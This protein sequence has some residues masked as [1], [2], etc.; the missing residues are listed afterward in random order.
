[1]LRSSLC[2]YSDAYILAKVTITVVNTAVQY[3]TN[4][5]GNK[6][7]IFKTCAPFINCSSRIN[8]TQADGASY[9]DVVILMYNLIKYSDSYLKTS[10]ILRQFY[11]DVPALNSDG[12]IIELTEANATKLFN[13]KVKLMG[14]TG[15]NGT[16]NVEIIIPLKYLSNI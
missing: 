11:R 14:E 3:Q 7:V 8:N 5:D 6:K 15:N 1:M 9:I 13:L 2:D 10:G 12:E 16:K 4:N